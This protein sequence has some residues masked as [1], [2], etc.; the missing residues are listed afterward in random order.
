VGAQAWLELAVTGGLSSRMATGEGVAS[1][2]TLPTVAA[3]PVLAAASAVPPKEQMPAR[4][5][6]ATPAVGGRIPAVAAEEHARSG[7][8]ARD[9][10]AQD[11]GE[12]SETAENTLK[13]AKQMLPPCLLVLLD[14]KYIKDK[15]V[16]SCTTEP[17]Q[18][19]VCDQP[20]LRWALQKGA[21]QATVVDR[22]E[23][24]L[25]LHLFMNVS[26]CNSPRPAT[27]S[28]AGCPRPCHLDCQPRARLRQQRGTPITRIPTLGHTELDLYSLYHAITKQGGVENV[29]ARKGWRDVAEELQLPP[30]CTDSGYRL[31]LHYC[32]F[33][34]P[35]ERR[36]FLR[37]DDN[38][39]PDLMV[40][41][42][43]ALLA[44]RV[45]R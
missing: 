44:R 39:P 40:R 5:V 18:A 23:F 42:H 19:L 38:I 14:P 28:P 17:V 45:P 25:R 34:Y 12:L 8:E 6:A 3:R 9:P 2:M 7:S 1:A 35:Y 26:R 24:L 36:Y 16:S 20:Y 37:L 32:N 15:P 13:D 11:E 22:A 33:L 10:A 41:P 21:K 29:I 27:L 4:A 31:K 43:A 30:S